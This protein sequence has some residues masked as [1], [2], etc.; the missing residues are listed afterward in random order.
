MGDVEKQGGARGKKFA[1]VQFSAFQLLSFYPQ[2]TLPPL[3]AAGIG[4]T[5][6]VSEVIRADCATAESQIVR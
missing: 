4:G 1:S 5:F 3:V 6:W 2:E